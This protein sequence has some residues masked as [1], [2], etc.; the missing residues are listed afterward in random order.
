[1]IW[2]TKVIP[3]K[4]SITIFS[5]LLGLVFIRLAPGF[6]AF[7]VGI[8]FGAWSPELLKYW[9]DLSAAM[10]AKEKIEKAVQKN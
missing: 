8:A 5:L 3:Y 2:N 4:V 6:T 10:E 7:T 1:M 9:H